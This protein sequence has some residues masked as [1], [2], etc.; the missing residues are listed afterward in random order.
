MARF[1]NPIKKHMLI[2]E[3]LIWRALNSEKQKSLE[4]SQ[5][6]KG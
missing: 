4:G 5:F 1:C 2:L 6:G 3:K